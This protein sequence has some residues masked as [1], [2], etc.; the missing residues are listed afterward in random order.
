MVFRGGEGAGGKKFPGRKDKKTEKW[1]RVWSLLIARL[2]EVFYIFVHNLEGLIVGWFTEIQKD[3]FES[4]FMLLGQLKKNNEYHF[5]V[6]FHEKY[7]SGVFPSTYLV[8]RIYEYKKNKPTSWYSFS[9]IP[10]RKR[11]SNN[12]NLEI[13]LVYVLPLMCIISESI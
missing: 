3:Y 7:C 2:N 11:G 13:I 10:R 12:M 5:S 9:Q 6:E 4:S 1:V 8:L